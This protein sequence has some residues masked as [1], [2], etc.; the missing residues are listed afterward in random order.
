MKHIEVP[1]FTSSSIKFYDAYKYI[2]PAESDNLLVSI[3]Y[4]YDRYMISAE[5]IWN[6]KISDIAYYYM[7]T[8]DYSAV[9]TDIRFEVV[10]NTK[11]YIALKYYGTGVTVG[12]KASQ[13]V[14]DKW[15]IDLKPF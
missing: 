1:S 12:E 11:D 3:I 8:K 5:D 7:Y 13:V 14:D 10:Q 4:S 15:Y 6:E 9:G 2:T